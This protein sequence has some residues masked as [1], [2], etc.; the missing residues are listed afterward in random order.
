MLCFLIIRANEKTVFVLFSHFLLCDFLLFVMC[1]DFLLFCRIVFVVLCSYLQAVF[2]ELRIEVF[3]PFLLRILGEL[4]NKV[5]ALLKVQVEVE[6]R[7]GDLRRG[8]GQRLCSHAA[9]L[10]FSLRRLI[11]IGPRA[12]LLKRKPARL[13]T[14]RVLVEVPR[15]VLLKRKGELKRVLLVLFRVLSRERHN[16]V[17]RNGPNGLEKREATERVKHVRDADVDGALNATLRLGGAL[18]AL[19]LVALQ[20]GAADVLLLQLLGGFLDGLCHCLAWIAWIAWWYFDSTSFP[21]LSLGPIGASIFYF[22][23]IC[24]HLKPQL[25]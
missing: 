16:G 8:N 15:A 13:N 23:E 19:A 22:L 10:P 18:V 4:L 11:D 1:C 3:G 20:D 7:V 12:T 17:E 25:V 24:M 2:V 9:R 14:H 21:Y 5:S 6:G